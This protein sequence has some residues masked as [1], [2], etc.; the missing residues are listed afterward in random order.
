MNLGQSNFDEEASISPCPSLLV[1]GLQRNV[2]DLFPLQSTCVSQC[3]AVFQSVSQRFLNGM[4]SGQSDLGGPMKKHLY[5]FD[6]LCPSVF[7]QRGMYSCVC[8]VF[9]SVVVS[10]FHRKMLMETQDRN[11]RWND[12]ILHQS[13]SPE[14]NKS[15][16][17][18]V[19]ICICICISSQNVNGDVGQELEME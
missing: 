14:F 19:F 1:V 13:S 7:Y 17:F 3:F 16:I 5:P 18:F 12:L 2:I 6:L 15:C 4:N 11:W 10:E 8:S 9:V